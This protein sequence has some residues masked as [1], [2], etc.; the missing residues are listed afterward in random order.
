MED[1]KRIRLFITLA[2]LI[3]ILHV[4]YYL[5]VYRAGISDLSDGGI[6]GRALTEGGIL[7]RLKANQTVGKLSSVSILIIEWGVILVIIFFLI[8]RRKIQDKKEFETLNLGKIRSEKTGTKTDLDNLYEVLKERKNL[9]LSTISK[10]YGVNRD[11]VMSWGRALE[12]AHLIRVEYPLFGE[13]NFIITE[14]AK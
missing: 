11:V 9:K 7:E 14:N 10:A 6:S 12:S 8:I 5:F 1:K 4:G 3:G 2:V 13:P